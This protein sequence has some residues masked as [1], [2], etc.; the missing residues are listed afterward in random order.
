[1]F[2]PEEW[3]SAEDICKGFKNYCEWCWGNGYGN[4]DICKSNLNQWLKD[5]NKGV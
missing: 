5:I 2:K 1:M 3:E 4:C